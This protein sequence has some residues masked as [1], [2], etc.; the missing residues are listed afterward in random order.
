MNP[1]LVYGR[2]PTGLGGKF[3]DTLWALAVAQEWARQRKGPV[4]MSIA[5]VEV[6]ESLRPLIE[7]QPYIGTLQ[8]C[9]PLYPLPRGTEVRVG[10]YQGFPDEPLPFYI[11]RMAGLEF[12]E[13]P[14]RG[15]SWV[16]CRFKFP[17]CEQ[18][19]VAYGFNPENGP[20]KDLFME[21]VTRLLPDNM[22]LLDV[23]ELCWV[24]A[25]KTIAG[26]HAFLG[27][28]SANYVLAHAVGQPR[29]VVFEPEAARRSDVFG[30][31]WAP[32]TLVS[33]PQQAV[34]AIRAGL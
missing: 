4:H 19:Y 17:M 32:D 9:W 26:A 24:D 25:A 16:N 30:C 23:T 10:N 12:G 22:P 14:A 20:A 33:E 15:H 2:G 3:G 6:R 8:I 27:C 18:P 29:V 34:D 13:Q 1:L 7:G 21:R 31:P 5:D 28:R 11:A